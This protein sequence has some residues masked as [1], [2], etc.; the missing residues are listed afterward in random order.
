MPKDGAIGR[1]MILQARYGRRAGPVLRLA[2]YGWA[3]A[4]QFALTLAIGVDAF[5]IYVA[6]TA[7]GMIGGYGSMAGVSDLLTRQWTS[8]GF[9]PRTPQDG[10]VGVRGASFDPGFRRAGAAGGCA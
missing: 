1:L 8:A 5:A 2:S 4:A 3:Y 7:L 6:A 10:D 9:A